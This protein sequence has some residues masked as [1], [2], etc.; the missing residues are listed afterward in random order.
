MSVRAKSDALLDCPLI[1]KKSFPALGHSFR[2][3][4]RVEQFVVHIIPFRFDP[5]ISTLD[6][7]NFAI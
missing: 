1:S 2:C 7:G 6:S 3:D 4:I 5:E